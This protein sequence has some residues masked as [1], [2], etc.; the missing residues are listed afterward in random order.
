V[1]RDVNEPLDDE[2]FASVEDVGPEPP[3]N[4]Q[5]DDV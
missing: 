1:E 3:E 5:V 2:E 4:P